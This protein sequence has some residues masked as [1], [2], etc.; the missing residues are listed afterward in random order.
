MWGLAW[1][2][3]PYKTEEHHLNIEK[4][5]A[6]FVFN[7]TYYLLYGIMRCETNKLKMHAKGVPT[8]KNKPILY[9]FWNWLAAFKFVIVSESLFRNVDNFVWQKYF[10]FKGYGHITP[11]TQIGKL[12]C[13]LYAILGIPFTL[14]FLSAMVQRL[15]YPTCSLLSLLFASRFVESKNRY[16]FSKCLP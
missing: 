10:F 3:Q 14:V 4:L 11:I 1:L 6:L 8:F 9:S 16:F 2:V 7:P 5:T 13:V 12:V 15:L